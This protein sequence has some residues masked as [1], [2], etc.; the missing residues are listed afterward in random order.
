MCWMWQED[1]K[2][3]MGLLSC[4]VLIIVAAKGRDADCVGRGKTLGPIEGPRWGSSVGAIPG[5]DGPGFLR[6]RLKRILCHDQRGVQHGEIF[7]LERSAIL[8]GKV[9]IA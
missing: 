9:A 6:K 1:E 4:P 7:A 2:V 8:L 3:R 5:P